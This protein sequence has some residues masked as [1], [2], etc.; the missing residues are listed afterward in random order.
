MREKNPRMERFLTE[1]TSLSHSAV[2]D[3][4]LGS[5]HEYDTLD[6]SSR[7]DSYSRQHQ[8]PHEKKKDPV[9]HRVFNYINTEFYKTDDGSNANAI[10]IPYLKRT[11]SQ[12]EKK[13]LEKIFEEDRN[14]YKK[15]HKDTDSGKEDKPED[16]KEETEIER[17]E[18]EIEGICN[19]LIF[20]IEL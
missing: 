2:S 10:K 17:T 19:D 5:L 4:T 1:D 18:L 11:Y 3:I 15:T 14:D 8:F 7:K 16:R 6:S 12:P 9:M 20:E 13:N